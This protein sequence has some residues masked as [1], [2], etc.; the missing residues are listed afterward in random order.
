V[1][2]NVGSPP[3]A[4]AEQPAVTTAESPAALVEL[5]IGF[6]STVAGA[7][8]TGEIPEVGTL[9]ASPSLLL[10]PALEWPFGRRIRFG[11][12]LGLYWMDD[13]FSVGEERRTLTSPEARLRLVFPLGSGFTLEGLGALGLGWWSSDG[14][15]TLLGWTSRAGIGAGYALS[16]GLDVTGMLAAFSAGTRPKGDPFAETFSATQ[17]ASFEAV[18]F[19]VGL[20]TF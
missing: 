17:A 16:E 14:L 6:G 8:F 1:V 4:A 13:P 20:R 11:V 3:P 18:L 7:R 2:V 15:G 5:G 9:D 10:V 12:G 19:L